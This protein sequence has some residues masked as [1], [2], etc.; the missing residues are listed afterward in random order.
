MKTDQTSGGEK[1]A[2][3]FVGTCQETIMLEHIHVNQCDS[4]MELS[5]GSDESRIDMIR[6]TQQFYGEEPCFATEKRHDC[7]ESCDW[8]RECRKLVAVWLR[9]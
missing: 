2:A 4:V 5:N 9:R 3:P 8:R 7:A 1:R 6:M